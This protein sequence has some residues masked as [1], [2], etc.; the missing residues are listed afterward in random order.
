MVFDTTSS[1]SGHMTGGCVAIQR[2]LGKPV[3]W[4]TCRHH[5]GEVILEQVCSNLNIETSKSPDVSVFCRFKQNWSKVS[6]SEIDNLDFPTIPP[7]IPP[8]KATHNNR[9]PIAGE[10]VVCKMWLQ[11]AGWVVTIRST[12][13][14]FQLQS[15]RCTSLSTVD[16]LNKN[17][18]VNWQDCW[19]I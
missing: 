9:M 7:W 19:T 18:S 6:H 5:V 11:G 1:N 13:G 17:G 4:L 15:P 16:G 2:K 8:A 14:R 10:A 3:I 12:R